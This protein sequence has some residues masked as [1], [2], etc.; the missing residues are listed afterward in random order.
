MTAN[1]NPRE[2]HVTTRIGL[3]RDRREGYKFLPRKVWRPVGTH[4]FGRTITAHAAQMA[5]WKARRGHQGYYN[6]R[7]TFILDWNWNMARKRPVKVSIVIFEGGNGFIQFGKG[8][9]RQFLIPFTYLPPEE[10]DTYEYRE[11]I[12][13]FFRRMIREGQI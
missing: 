1:A 10:F 5:A 8:E 3:Y 12:R 11:H 6:P 7:P 4:G 2:I 9:V 13:L